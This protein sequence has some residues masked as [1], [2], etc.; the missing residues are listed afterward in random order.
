[1]GVSK[2]MLGDQTVM[3]I[4]NDNVAAN[5]MLQG[6]SAHNSAGEP[7]S[8]TLAG[9]EIVDI[10]EADYI[11]LRGQSSQ[12]QGTGVY[13]PTKFYNI[14]NVNAEG[15]VVTAPLTATANSTTSLTFD[16]TTIG[17][18]DAASILT[19]SHIEIEAEDVTTKSMPLQG[20]NTLRD[21]YARKTIQNTGSCTIEFDKQPNNVEF[22]LWIR[23][24]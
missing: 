1:M 13:D 22:R 20:D 19:T 24:L 12:A 9:Q 18:D 21:I 11:T 10:L 8:G 23:N 4:S 3:D 14:T 7:I 6:T 5:K 17:A 15:W 16:A 2:V